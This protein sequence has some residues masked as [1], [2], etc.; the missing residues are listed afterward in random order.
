LNWQRSHFTNTATD[1]DGDLLL[2]SLDSGAP[3]NATI[4]SATGIFSW[5]PTEAQGSGTNL[6]SVRVTD[7][8]VRR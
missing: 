4:N 8:G 1:A 5:M 7:N 3:T 6:I 2:F